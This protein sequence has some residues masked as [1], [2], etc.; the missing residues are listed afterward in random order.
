MPGKFHG[1]R[2]P[3]GYSP[4]GCKAILYINYLKKFSFI[5]CSIFYQLF[6]YTVCYDLPLVTLEIKNTVLTYQRTIYIFYFQR[7][8][9]SIFKTCETMENIIKQNNFTYC[10]YILCNCYLFYIFYKVFSITSHSEQNFIFSHV[11]T[12]SNIAYSLDLSAS[13]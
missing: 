5:S 13:I 6:H 12:I 9:I 10:D 7:Q 8:Q 2:S 1:H 11:F 3:A 4:W